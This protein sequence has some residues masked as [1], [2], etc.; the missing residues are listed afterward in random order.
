MKLIKFRIRN[1]R[2]I[3]DSG[4]VTVDKLVCLVG[5]NESGKSNL[6][7][8]LTSL[9]PADGRKPLNKIKDFPRGRRLEECKDDTSVV[10]TQW[11]LSVAQASALGT[12]FGAYGT[13]VT[14]VRIGRGYA[15]T[16]CVNL[17]VTRPTVEQDEIVNLLQRMGP[18]WTARIVSIIEPN[19]VW[20]RFKSTVEKI[21]ES[22]EWATK[23]LAAAAEFRRQLEE[24]EFTL[25]E[26]R[27][28]LLAALESKAKLINNF[29]K[30]YEE[31]CAQVIAW[32][33][34]FVY[35]SE[36]P[37][38]S[39]HQNL[40][41]FIN[42][43]GKD[44]AKKEAEDNFEKMA[45]VAGFNSQEL[46]N[47]R[48]DHET[49][50]QLLNRAGA[51]VTQEIRRLWKDRPLKVR[52]HLD[53][54]YLDTLISD[55]NPVYEVEVNLD[56]RSRGFRWFFA[57]YIT[58][59]ADTHGGNADG[60]VLLIDEPGLH[61]HAKSQGD[62][63]NHMRTDFKNQIIYTT[64]SPYMVPPDAINVVRTVNIDASKGTYVTDVPG[65]DLPTLFPLQAALGHN[66]AQMLL[67]GHSS[68]VVESVSDFW[69]LSPVNAYLIADGTTALPEDLI[70]TPAGG[71]PKISY[72][73][74][75]F[76]SEERPVLVLLNDDR[77][78]RE[79]Q[80]DLVKNRLMRDSAVFATEG[81][82]DPKPAEA[83]IEDLIDPSVYAEL[84]N[85]TYAKEL[86][87]K[88]LV[89]DTSIP[90]I[91]KRYEKAF[92]ALEIKFH[93]ARPARE[94]MARMGSDPASVLP[95][96]SAT[97]FVA[98]F[99]AVREQYDR[100][101]TAGQGSPNTEWSS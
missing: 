73:A 14:D 4:D 59:A 98:V 65:G 66:L 24:D 72:V 23:T 54:P 101:K 36:F 64:Q 13:T 100:M 39:G 26:E 81:F 21:S 96:A 29:D 16:L 93:K 44:A 78:G 67:V 83:D 89:L 15:S 63:L 87:G 33:P 80:S 95:T 85:H 45:K 27:D 82:S 7:L 35:V 48:S 97:K 51:V 99:K 49:R 9:N 41:E 57:F 68:L 70:I 52:Y 3:N 50:N 37:Q 1:F 34:T 47:L 62:L 86:V 76:A 19:E 56:E 88:T 31:A 32:L 46:E 84:V 60:A 25:T 12:L 94:F 20:Q 22:A 28:R 17:P 42:R 90:R 79:I 58:F 30:V 6:L 8:A 55:P 74:A 77:A 69:I 71:T 11:K 92:S 53:G 18:E 40:D 38:L 10:E 5:R 91:V 61:L 75:L 43:R 2:S